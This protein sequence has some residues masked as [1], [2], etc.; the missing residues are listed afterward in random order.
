M[1][2]VLIIAYGN[3]LRSDD[4]V[5]WRAA[6][7]LRQKFSPDAIAID[8]L[9]QLAPE[10]AETVSRFPCVIFVDAESSPEGHPGEIR[11]ETLGDSA[12]KE[13]TTHFSHALSPFAVLRL[14]ETLYRAKPRAFSVTVTGQNFDHGEALSPAVAS[15]LPDLVTRVALLVCQSLDPL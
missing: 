12:V 4:A 5:A 9:H 2:R 8:C 3:P 11:V 6:E 15:A 14:A 13:Q 10:L 1:P 7:A